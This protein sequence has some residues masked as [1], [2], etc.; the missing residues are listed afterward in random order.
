MPEWVDFLGLVRERGAPSP[1]DVEAEAEGGGGGLGFAW[2]RA[3][4]GLTLS[5]RKR[6]IMSEMK[7]V[8]EEAL[9]SAIDETTLSIMRSTWDVK[10]GASRSMW[11]A[12]ASVP[13]VDK[14]SSARSS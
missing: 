3:V 8:D 9:G 12:W 5:R 7:R 4:R 11:M 13:G 10:R 2:V 6:T 1:R 14:Y